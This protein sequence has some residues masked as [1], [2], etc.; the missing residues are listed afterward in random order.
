MAGASLMRSHHDFD[1]VNVVTLPLFLFSATF[2]PLSVYPRPLQLVVQ[3]TPLY[4][5]AAL[6][7]SLAFGDVHAGV[8]A[9]VAYL[10]VL[11]LVGA[12]IASRRFERLLLT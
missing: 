9:H 3:C 6:M 8:L 12:A 1:F 5:G 7:R 10:L 4:H 11:G 2:Y